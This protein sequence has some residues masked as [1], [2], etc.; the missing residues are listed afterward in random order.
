MKIQKILDEFVKKCSKELKLYS[1]VQFGS[2][3]YSK[4]FDDI[5][6][7]FVFNQK[8]FSPKELLNLRKVIFDFEKKYSEIA[9]DFGE[10]S[11]RKRKAKFEITL[12]LLSMNEL[13]IQYYPNDLFLFKSL[14]EDKNKKILFG[15]NPFVNLNFE[16][17]KRHLFE[18]LSV[19]LIWCL[20]KSLDDKNYKLKA[21]YHLFKTF[22]RAM[23]INKGHFKKIELLKKFKEKFKKEINL[24]KNS[25]E[26]IKNKVKKEDFKD[27]LKFSESCLKY[28]TK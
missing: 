12:I 3:T 21:C 20:R 14:K 10:T 7:M 6:L 27:I 24:P 18:M 19:E 5:D 4:N 1:I 13:N 2:S 25:K 9:F 26:I 8:V 22:L 11:T 23:L 28:L 17:T 16:L 15:K